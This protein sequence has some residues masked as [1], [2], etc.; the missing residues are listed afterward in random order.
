[1]LPLVGVDSVLGAAKAP[2]PARS[3]RIRA[4]TAGV[5]LKAPTDLTRIEATIALLERARKVFEADDY[6]VQTLRV[7][8]PPI[9]AGLKDRAREVALAQLQAL[10]ELGDA[11]RTFEAAR[12]AVD[13]EADHARHTRS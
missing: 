3:L 5:G 10:D 7:A 11:E 6:E 13:G 8:T 12:L 4:I 1:M 2:A 9:M